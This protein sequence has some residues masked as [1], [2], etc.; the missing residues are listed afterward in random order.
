MAGD[1]V[2]F[3]L[4]FSQYSQEDKPEQHHET[5]FHSAHQQYHQQWDLPSFEATTTFS[6]QDW[7]W[8]YNVSGVPTQDTDTSIQRSQLDPLLDLRQP[9]PQ[10]VVNKLDVQSLVKPEG[11][12]WKP[13][14]LPRS[15]NVTHGYYNHA[16]ARS[17]GVM[18]E[19]LPDEEICSLVESD[20]VSKLDSGF[21]SQALGRNSSS[22]RQDINRDDQSEVPAISGYHPATKVARPPAGRILSDSQV[23]G[24]HSIAHHGRRRRSSQPLPPCSVCGTFFPKN[25]S[26]QKKHERKHTKP[27][28]CRFP[29]CIAKDIGFSTDNDRD[30]HYKSAKHREAPTKG[31]LKG[32]ICIACTDG[33]S[34]LWPRQD[35]FKAHCKRKH[36]DFNIEDLMKRSEH[37]LRPLHTY[38]EDN[39][40]TFS[41]PTYQQQAFPQNDF[42]ATYDMAP[43]RQGEEGLWSDKSAALLPIDELAGVGQA[44]HLT[45]A[46]AYRVG[47]VGADVPFGSYNG[48]RYTPIGSWSVD[49][50][51]PLHANQ[52]AVDLGDF[53]DSSM[54]T[55]H[56]SGLLNTNCNE[57]ATT[58]SIVSL[59][60]PSNTSDGEG[61][62]K[63]T[64]CDKSKRRRCELKYVV[65]S[66][67][68]ISW[69]Q[70]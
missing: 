46:F 4:R 17:S 66:A 67:P 22:Y 29:E 53:N 23:A 21:Y 70:H 13:L 49:V 20:L 48:P 54:Q 28:K 43:L 50:A 2:S 45:D 30:R 37:D 15:T 7:P 33:K 27:F 68:Y 38:S 34:K 6:L 3:Q 57:V 26:D 36:M 32:F 9:P 1:H 69:Q 55:M 19:P 12:A 5:K 52:L 64:F 25:L 8:P 63:C 31:S 56:Q 16:Y 62:F 39:N 24:Y 60:S 44:L 10:D 59:Q 65:V 42:G 40:T 58:S 11:E 18:S 41:D 51:P 61:L 47:P 14:L 35:N